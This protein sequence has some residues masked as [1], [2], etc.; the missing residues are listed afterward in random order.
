MCLDDSSQPQLTC[1]DAGDNSEQDYVHPPCEKDPAT[2]LSSAGQG[3]HYIGSSQPPDHPNIVS[4][5]TEDLP[6]PPTVSL[7]SMSPSSLSS[8]P[9]KMQLV[10]VV[11]V[12]Q[13]GL[14][15][16]YEVVQP[17]P[18]PSYLRTSPARL[19]STHAGGPFYC[20]GLSVF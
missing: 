3:R 7:T 17:V 14:P 19:S 8:C 16:C 11:Y 2:S 9:S 18:S 15:T 20:I 13:D 12:N 1:S 4:T 5:A 10:P 6:Q